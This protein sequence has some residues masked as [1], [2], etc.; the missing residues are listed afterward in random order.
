MFSHENQFI[1]IKF[2]CISGYL[3]EYKVQFQIYSMGN[4]LNQIS[5]GHCVTVKIMTNLDI[6]GGDHQHF[7]FCT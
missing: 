3:T 7:C 4:M 5:R 2:T 6:L 1:L